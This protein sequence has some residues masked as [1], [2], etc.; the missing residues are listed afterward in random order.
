MT[1][2]YEDEDNKE[3]RVCIDLGTLHQK[4]QEWL[5][6]TKAPSDMT[7][8]GV[9]IAHISISMTQVTMTWVQSW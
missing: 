7:S 5:K 2:V 8:I 3:K 4:A 1:M 6:Q 9:M